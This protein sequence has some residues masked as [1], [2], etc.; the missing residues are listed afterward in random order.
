MK[1]TDYYLLLLFHVGMND[2]A[3]WNIGRI[4]EYYKAMGVQVKNTGAQV[5]FSILPVGGKRAARNR[6]IM[7]IQIP[8][9]MAGADTTLSV[10]MTMGISMKIT[11][12]Y[13]QMGSGCV[14]KAGLSSAAGWQTYW[15]G[16]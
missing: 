9:Y 7:P 2:T 3:S 14:E 12:C 16:L 5:T 13:G 4:K 10:F 6:H 11:T 1:S 8:G 15:G